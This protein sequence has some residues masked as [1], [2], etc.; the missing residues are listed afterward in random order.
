MNANQNDD[1]VAQLFRAVQDL[2]NRR[3][4]QLVGNGVNVNS[5]DNE[6]DTPLHIQNSPHFLEF[7]NSCKA[8]LRLIKRQQV[9]DKSITF[10]KV[11]INEDPHLF[12]KN[13]YLANIIRD[14]DF[15]T[16]YP[17]YRK[18]MFLNFIKVRPDQKE[19]LKVFEDGFDFDRSD[20][21]DSDFF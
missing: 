14:R 1:Q 4:V 7:L 10:Y 19:H 21:D 5:T 16:R 12:A 6:G 3:I 20:S 9:F 18:R 15:V 17:I 2:E 8:E 13:K 11:L